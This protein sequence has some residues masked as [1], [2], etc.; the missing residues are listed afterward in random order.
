MNAAKNAS[1]SSGVG[2]SRSWEYP[3]AFVVELALG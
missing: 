2:G 1:E 3:K